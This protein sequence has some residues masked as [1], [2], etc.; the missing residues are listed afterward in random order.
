MSKLNEYWWLFHNK[1]NNAFS[2]Y[3]SNIM[4]NRIYYMSN[5]K[6]VHRDHPKYILVIKKI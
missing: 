3:H 4:K 5:L 2:I 6:K 1:Y